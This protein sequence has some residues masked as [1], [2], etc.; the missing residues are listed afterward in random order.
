MVLSD[1]TIRR[2]VEEEGL[3]EPFNLKNLSSNSYDLTL[4]DEMKDI[5]LKPGESRLI[6]TKEGVN[7]PFDVTAKT[8]S[9]SSFARCG[10]S[11]GDIGGWVDAGFRGNLSLLAV[12]FG[13]STFS[14][15]N[16]DKICQ[17]VFFKSDEIVES[18]YNGHYQDSRGLQQSW[19]KKII[20]EVEVMTKIKDIS[21]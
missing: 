12:N 16:V 15:K 17:I 8:I 19:F 7:L 20:P 21:K 4:A 18:P 10:V 3:I 9:K 13:D 11:I 2:L 14:L 5:E 1:K 6:V